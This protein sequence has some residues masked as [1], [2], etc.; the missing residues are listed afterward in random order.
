[1]R[2]KTLLRS[3]ERQGSFPPRRKAPSSSPELVLPARRS[4]IGLAS[5]ASAQRSSNGPRVCARAVMSS[6]FRGLGYDIAERMGLA[7]DLQ[8]AGYAMK[9][10][11][12]VDAQGRR[13]AGFGTSVFR[14]FT[15]GRYTS[16]PRSELSRLIYRAIEGRCEAIFYDSITR[17][18]HKNDGVEVAFQ[19]GPSRTFDLVVGAD[20]LHSKVRELVFGSEDRFT[21][22][23]G[24]KVAAFE[25]EGYRPRDDLVYVSHAVPGKQVARFALRGDR[26]LFLLVFAAAEPTRIAAHDVQGH[27]AAIRAEF[28][29]VGWEC[30]QILAALDG[31]DDVYFDDVSQIRMVTWAKGRVALLGDAGFCPSLLAGQGSALAMIG[32]YVLAGELSKSVDDPEAALRRYEDLL[33]PFMNAKQKGRRAIRR[34]LRAE[35]QARHL[36][37]QP[38]DQ[39]LRHPGPCPAH[40]RE[41]R[42]RPARAPR[43]PELA[44]DCHP[45][46]L[47]PPYHAIGGPRR[48]RIRGSHRQR[49]P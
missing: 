15:G 23:L 45:R 35:N 6:T 24:Y 27:K 29:D 7:P 30:P 41:Q 4:P 12:F 33:R 36:F 17:L 20:G 39:S 5:T 3:A 44:R 8:A 14:Q 32:A 43:V 11:R 28:S 47:T 38:D 13:I 19:R 42:S 10:L 18:E 2:Q 9:E 31:C 22:Y 34:F 40:L 26:T 46:R 1:M 21:K 49:T 16:L 37:S 48:L 25:V